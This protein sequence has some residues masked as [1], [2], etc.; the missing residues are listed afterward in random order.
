VPPVAL[1]DGLAP[2]NTLS[3][4]YYI[5]TASD[6]TE[7]R[8]KQG[9][10]G[11]RLFWSRP[12]SRTRK[13]HSFTYLVHTAKLSD[14]DELMTEVLVIG[15]GGAG[16]RAAIAAAESGCRTLVVS[17]GTP[18]LGSA[19]LLSDGFFASAGPGLTPAE[20]AK[21]TLDIGYHLNK[22]ELVK[23]F[24]EEIRERLEEFEL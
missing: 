13:R 15:S 9:P 23:V 4:T 11:Q 1:P 5:A 16:L 21:M 18:A 12:C 8:S 22:P 14:M 2:V 10:A 17:K 3:L 6:F 7:V 24:S 20:H 19:T